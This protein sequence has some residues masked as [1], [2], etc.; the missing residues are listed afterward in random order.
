MP[1]RSCVGEWFAADAPRAYVLRV[2]SLFGRAPG[3]P[4][5]KGSAA[6]IAR[7]MLAGGAPRVFED[8]TVSPTFVTD[9]AHATRRLLEAGSAPGLYHCVNSGRCTW[10]EFAEC[11]ARQL[12]IEPRVE[13]VRLAEVA[14]PAERPRFCAL[15]NA[16]LAAAGI[17]MPTWQD[18]LARSLGKGIT[19]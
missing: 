14:M 12:G 7:T 13:R 16:K 10:L 5:P 6:V 9:A 2:E 1:R 17:P 18:G 8:R 4:E 11:L 19:G 15:S 3:G